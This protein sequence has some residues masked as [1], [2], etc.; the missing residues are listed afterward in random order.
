MRLVRQLAAIVLTVA[1]F[2]MILRRVPLAAL[3][4]ALRQADVRVF[5]SL[6]V[7]NTLFY[8]AW[9]T[10][11]LTVVIRWFHGEV[12]YHDLLP[13]RA[14]SYVV[15]FF[16]TNLGRGA[17]AAY[18]TRTLQAPFLELGS[19]V[20]FLVL[21]EYTQL[22][23]WA[24]LGLLGLRTEVSRSLLIVAGGVALF[25][26]V[27]RWLVAPREWSLARTFRLTTPARCVQIV[28]L[29]A[30]MFLVSLLVHYHA[31][32]AFGIRIPFLQMLT[33]LPVIFMIAALPITVGHLGTTQAAW[34][35][36][37]GAYAEPPQLL[38]F[39]LAAHF[40]FTATRAVLGVAWLPAA[41]SDLAAARPLRE[42]PRSISAA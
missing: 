8:F 33:F 6:M 35:V 29:R 4:A 30:P 13:V 3:D 22:V 14:A 17:L 2:A 40:V 36:F 34:I 10:L 5:L 39:S 23:I 25:W 7:P 21:T 18:L 24:L 41:W 27:V 20:L 16:N 37:F 19:T 28:L 9:D 12:R 15:G 32:H 26:L 38:A 11:V 31:A 1:I 42:K